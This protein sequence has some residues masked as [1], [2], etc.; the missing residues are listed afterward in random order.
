[1]RQT[2]YYERNGSPS[3]HKLAC[4][5]QWEPTAFQA[6]ML[7]NGLRREICRKCNTI[8]NRPYRLTIG[9]EECSAG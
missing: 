8:E 3:M 4:N 2:T 9:E 7:P 6:R 1:M 5:H